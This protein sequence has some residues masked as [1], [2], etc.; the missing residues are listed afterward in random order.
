M[1]SRTWLVAV[2]KGSKCLAAENIVGS[3]NYLPRLLEICSILVE[4]ELHDTEI[5]VI[6]DD[7][8]GELHEDDIRKF[9][10][11]YNIALGEIDE[12]E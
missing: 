4:G 9:A 6:R 10:R 11:A 5:I 1:I 12:V 8:C 3:R 7:W 2:M